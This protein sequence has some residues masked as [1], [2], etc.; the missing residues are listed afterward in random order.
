MGARLRVHLTAQENQTLLDLRKA[1]GLPQ[2]VK[3]RAEVVRLRTSEQ[4][5]P[6][7]QN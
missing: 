2:R 1:T 5:S 7:S 3:D 4:S 6:P